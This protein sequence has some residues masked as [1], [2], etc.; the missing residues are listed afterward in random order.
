MKDK[1]R[2]QLQELRQDKI[3]TFVDGHGRYTLSDVPNLMDEIEPEH[4]NA[5]KKLPPDKREY[6][7]ET[8]ARDVKWKKMAHERFGF[9]C[10]CRNCRNTF[11]REDN[12]PYIEVHH[13]IPLC[14][15]G[16]DHIENLSVLCAHHHRFAHYAQ[17][18]E[19]EIFREQLLKRVR[20][21]L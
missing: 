7:I 17:Y 18:D 8:Y 4:F 6:L 14:D 10:L 1:I 19:R 9:H 20:S 3:L 13:I 2:Q 5:I 21:L 16:E 15:G 12:T 11:L